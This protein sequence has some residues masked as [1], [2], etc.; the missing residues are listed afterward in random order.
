[1]APF[2]KS[3]LSW[4]GCSTELS[5]LEIPTSNTSPFEIIA[6][7]NVSAFISQAWEHG[8]LKL[9]NSQNLSVVFNSTGKH[10]V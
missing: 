2:S 7:A 8:F 5:D 10:G 3:L 6:H 9:L 4:R 1:M